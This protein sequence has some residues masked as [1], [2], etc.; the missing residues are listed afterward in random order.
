MKD[1]LRGDANK[2]EVDVTEAFFVNNLPA[3]LDGENLSL[4]CLCINLA[5]VRARR[6]T[7]S[8][9]ALLAARQ[10]WET[11]YRDAHRAT[12]VWLA[13]DDQKFSRWTSPDLSV[14]AARE[15]SV[16]SRAGSLVATQPRPAAK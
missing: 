3:R 1:H 11:W 10:S 14:Q 15:E 13:S 16:Q 4:L 7:T 9:G 2:L 6:E 5:T 8:Y 12:N